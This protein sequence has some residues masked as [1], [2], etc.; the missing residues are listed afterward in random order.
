MNP[1]MGVTRRVGQGYKRLASGAV[2][3][4]NSALCS[5]RDAIMLAPWPPT[6]IFSCKTFTIAS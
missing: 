3:Q 4:L 2:M 1:A 6:R 5:G